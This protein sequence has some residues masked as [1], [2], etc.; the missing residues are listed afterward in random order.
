MKPDRCPSEVEHAKSGL[1][2]EWVPSAICL[3]IGPT[4]LGVG[5]ISILL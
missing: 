3:S 1:Q 5:S 2:T 4:N